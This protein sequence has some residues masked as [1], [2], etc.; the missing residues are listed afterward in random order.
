MLIDPH[1]TKYF[2]VNIKVI[3]FSAYRYF[4]S[5]ISLSNTTHLA[6]ST[7]FSILLS[8]PLSLITKPLKLPFL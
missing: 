3:S 5:E 7:L 4:S 2:V 8:P 1:I 6:F